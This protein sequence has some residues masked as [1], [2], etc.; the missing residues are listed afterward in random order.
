MIRKY[1]YQVETVLDWGCVVHWSEE[2]VLQGQNNNLFHELISHEELLG[3]TTD[4]SVSVFKSHSSESSLLNLHGNAS[5][6]IHIDLDLLGWM[7]TGVHGCGENVV[8][9]VSDFVHH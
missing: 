1:T 5:I 4:V 2:M 3:G 8:T 6:Q 9:L 7:D